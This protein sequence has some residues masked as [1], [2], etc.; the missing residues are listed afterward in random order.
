MNQ[1]GLILALIFSLVIAIFATVNQQ[2]VEINYLYGRAEVPAVVVILGS[3]ILGAL[4]MFL[5]SVIRQVRANFRI[6][7]LRNEVDELKENLLSLEGERDA[8]LA[9]VG[10]L[11]E[12][13]STVEAEALQ[14]EQREEDKPAEKES[15]AAEGEE[16]EKTRP[17]GEEAEPVEGATHAEER[18]SG[19]EEPEKEE[20]EK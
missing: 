13:E 4:V 1:V 17:E 18:H 3:A 15:A 16:R 20:E 2:P 6:R 14:Q 9:Q 19:E 12:A 5:L 7:G 10:Q 8:L 11:Q